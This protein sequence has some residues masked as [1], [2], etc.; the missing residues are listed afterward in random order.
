VNFRM[1]RPV[2]QGVDVLVVDDDPDVRD[3]VQFILA[4]C[5]ARVRTAAS[6][7][8]AL[9][10]LSQAPPDVLISDI[11][12][13]GEDGYSLIR[14]VRAREASRGRRIA[15]L[16]LSAWGSAEDRQRALA[17]GFQTHLAKPVQPETLARVVA[18]LSH[19]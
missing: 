16:A 10:A 6:A 11:G 5:G 15:A 2:L 3:L 1:D 18:G 4:Q 13:P 19:R 7:A 17:A 14:K 8:E 12:M 9:E